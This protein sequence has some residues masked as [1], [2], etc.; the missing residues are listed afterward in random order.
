M[1]LT[2]A[3]RNDVTQALPLV[4]A[5]PPVGGKPGRPRQ[6]PDSADA[7]R[8]YDSEELREQLRAREIVPKIARRRQARGSGS[9]V[10]RYAAEQVQAWL[11][12]FKRL[13][14]RYERASSCTR[15]FLLAL[16]A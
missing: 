4:D 10:Y 2:G 16:P 14:T 5:I 8:A 15:P 3:N 7:A 1:I 12:G 6:R 13:R 11:H 9:G